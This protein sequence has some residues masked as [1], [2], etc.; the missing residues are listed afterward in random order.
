V[1]GF[2]AIATSAFLVAFLASYA[3][4]P[5]IR[6]ISTWIGFVD[7]PDG[8]RKM[9]SNP[10]AL[11]GGLALIAVTP[12]VAFVLSYLVGPDIFYSMGRWTYDEDFPWSMVG[13]AV[14][15]GILGIAGLVDDAVGMKGSHK[16]LWQ[17]VAAALVS[18][19]GLHVVRLGLLNQQFELWIFGSVVT[20]VWL[21]AS[22]NSF[23]LIDGVDGLAGSIG[24]VFS[25]TLGILALH[26]G[27]LVDA[28]IVFAL[29]GALLGFLRYNFSP[30]TI[31]L[32]DT[33]SMFVGLI[34][35]AVALRC[36]TK[37]AATLAFS[38]P[39]AI[40]AIPFFDSI[41]AVL[42]RKLTGRSIY[43]T[44]RGHFHHVLLTYGLGA[45]QAVAIITVLCTITSAAAVVGV[46]YGADWI[47]IGTVACVIG[48]LVVTRVFGHVEFLLLN[49][50]LLGFG[51]SL[52]SPAGGDYSVS[53]E[54][55]ISLQGNRQWDELWGTLV[56]STDKF[57]LVSLTLNL[58]LPQLH[59][60]FFATWRRSGQNRRELNWSVEIPIIHDECPVGRL[61]AAGMHRLEMS[62]FI[63]FVESLE[64]QL[65]SSIQQDLAIQNG[66]TVNIQAETGDPPP[67]L[68]A[69]S[70]QGSVFGLNSV[71]GMK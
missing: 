5:L 41:A 62:Q 30:A 42:R 8:K 26:I 2:M 59:E 68:A 24:V 48:M 28:I 49:S 25:L 67:V 6:S 63:D 43:A 35:G 51:R 14:A 1:T 34:L 37:Q 39:L 16:L 71:H 47:A 57:H 33:G 58:T 61:R 55:R 44:D 29:A 17:V 66:E 46:I 13:I 52:A 11:G 31:Y 3:I 18:G 15:A 56:E 9:Q 10:V 60:D 40:W 38:V 64:S 45:G 53:K 12:V 50:Q 70:S 4:T 22:I 69:G 32:G 65:C 54:R 7:R 27:L 19:S 23:N 21:L 36:S 20:I